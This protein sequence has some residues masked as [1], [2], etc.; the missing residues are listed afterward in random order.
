VHAVGANEHVRAGAGPVGEVGGD[1]M[2][3][4]IDA[5][6]LLGV[7]DSHAGSLRRV[8]ENAVQQT[9]VDELT[10]RKPVRRGH[11]ATRLAGDRHDRAC[12][13]DSGGAHGVVGADDLQ[14]S[15]TVGLESKRTAD[16]VGRGWIRRARLVHGRVDAC[17]GQCG[18]RDWP[19]DSAADDECGACCGHGVSLLL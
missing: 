9:A 10:R 5:N 2:W 19:G 6:E 14:R 4:L 3:V 13:G 8:P 18:G 15:Q 12:D 11:L 16:P 17:H 1:T 7:V